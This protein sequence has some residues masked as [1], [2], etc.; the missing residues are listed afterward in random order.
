[1]PLSAFLSS[2]NITDNST[3]D[4]LYSSL[5]SCN[6]HSPTHIISERRHST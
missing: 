2:S 4:H 3:F 5:S 6:C 1:M